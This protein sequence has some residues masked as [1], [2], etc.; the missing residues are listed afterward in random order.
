MALGA[1]PGTVLR[2]V[3]TQ[4]LRVALAGTAIG[5]I[6]AIPATRYLRAQLYG[7]DPV[8]PATLVAVILVLAAAS[9]AAAYVPARRATRVDPVIALRSD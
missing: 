6:A 5:L 9:I 3:L 2:H 1:R 4:A 7:V 8:D